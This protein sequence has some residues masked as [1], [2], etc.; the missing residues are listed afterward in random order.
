MSRKTKIRLYVS[1]VK[2]VL[3]YGSETWRTTKNVE[4]IR[5]F[6]G[7]CLRRIINIRWP[8]VISNSELSER[9]G[10]KN[11]LNEIIRRQ[12]QYIGHILRMDNNRHV[13]KILTWTPLGTRKPGRPKCT[14]RRDIAAE[15]KRHGY[16]WNQKDKIANDRTSWRSLVD[17][18]C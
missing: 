5:G 3:L 18:L 10:V 8:S 14:W 4:R 13:K 16:T 2:S 12:W 15:I 7:R 6:E 11:I 9:T 1:N 17:A